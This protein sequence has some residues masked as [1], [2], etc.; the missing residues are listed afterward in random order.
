VRQ[1]HANLL[2]STLAFIAS[3]DAP[4]AHKQNP[5]PSVAARARD[6]MTTAPQRKRIMYMLV[7]AKMTMPKLAKLVMRF[8]E[9]DEIFK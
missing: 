1:T 2:T 4:Q 3:F 8:N 5:E 9:N 7:L 6:A